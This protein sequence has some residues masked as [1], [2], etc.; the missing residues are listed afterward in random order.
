MFGNGEK[1]A[2]AVLHSHFV[3]DTQFFFLFDSLR[4]KVDIAASKCSAKGAAL[5]HLRLQVSR[6]ADYPSRSLEKELVD[7]PLYVSANSHHFVHKVLLSVYFEAKTTKGKD[8]HFTHLSLLVHAEHLHKESEVDLKILLLHEKR[9]NKLCHVLEADD[10]RLVHR[11]DSRWKVPPPHSRLPT[12][13]GLHL[14][15]VM[16]LYML[17]LAMAMQLDEGGKT[18]SAKSASKGLF[19]LFALM[20]ASDVTKKIVSPPKFSIAS[21]AGEA[22]RRWRR[23]NIETFMLSEQVTAEIIGA[24]KMSLAVTTMQIGLHDAQRRAQERLRKKEF[25]KSILYSFSLCLFTSK[26]VSRKLHGV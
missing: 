18:T 2:A 17:S 21:W 15:K 10:Q 26:K 12:V 1:K 25:S 5:N 13:S 7:I 24:K 20:I 11:C 9:E 6:F 23:L 14:A 8:V 4:S 19:F 3:G 16:M 22:R